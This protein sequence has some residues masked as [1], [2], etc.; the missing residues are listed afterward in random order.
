MLYTFLGTYETNV[1]NDGM[2]PVSGLTFDASGALYG[3]TMQGGGFC[4][5]GVVAGCGTVYKL[6]PTHIRLR[7]IAS[8]YIP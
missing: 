2:Y 1:V 5:E 8:V 4:V 3:T 7:R 6:T